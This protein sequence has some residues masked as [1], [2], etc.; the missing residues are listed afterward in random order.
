MGRG[1][2]WATVHGIAKN[3][4]PVKPLSTHSVFKNVLFK[5]STAVS[6][7]LTF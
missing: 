6:V 7:H 5:L 2:W 3:R 1:A 4:P